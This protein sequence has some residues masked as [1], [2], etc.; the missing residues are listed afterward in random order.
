MTIR[1]KGKTILQGAI[2]SEYLQTL[3]DRLKTYPDTKFADKEY[4]KR[5][6]NT[7]DLINL[8]GD[9]IHA[10]E[11]DTSEDERRTGLEID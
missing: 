7:L 8:D 9:K 6:C 1:I 11:R 2:A 5:I 3:I 4:E 10:S